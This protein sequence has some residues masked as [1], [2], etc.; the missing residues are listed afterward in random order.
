M[1]GK[2]RRYQWNKGPRLKEATTSEEREDIRQNLQE[3]SR[4]GG[5]KP[6]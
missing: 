2:T 5:L 4:D 3:D 6:K 1:S